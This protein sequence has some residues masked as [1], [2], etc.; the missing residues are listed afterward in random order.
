MIIKNNELYKLKHS[1]IKKIA[2]DNNIILLNS[3]N[4]YK[5]KTSLISELI[6][7]LSKETLENIYENYKKKISN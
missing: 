3:N 2:K 5:S 7:I 6:N 4:K 1:D